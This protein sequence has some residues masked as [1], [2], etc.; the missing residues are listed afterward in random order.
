MIYSK[1]DQLKQLKIYE[2][3]V[4]TPQLLERL[5]NIWEDSVRATHLF[6][7]DA[8]VNQ[9]KEYVPQALRHIK[10]RNMMRKVI[11]IRFYI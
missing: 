2:V 3:K 5:L 1:R 10:E 11:R 6:L 9:I 8:E 7:T 4:R